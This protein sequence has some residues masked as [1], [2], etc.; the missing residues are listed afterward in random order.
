VSEQ[1]GVC[2]PGKT[3]IHLN[4]AK[5]TLGGELERTKDEEEWTGPNG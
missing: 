3:S 2:T 1:H 5:L 4:P